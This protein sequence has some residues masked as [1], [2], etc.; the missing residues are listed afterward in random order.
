MSK[1]FCRCPILIGVNH[2]TAYELPVLASGFPVHLGM[3]CNQCYQKPIIGV[4]FKCSDCKNFV[5]CQNC[6]FIK[7]SIS[8][9]N[10]KGHTN[11]HNFEMFIIETS[12]ERKTYT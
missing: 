11:Q 8:F 6:Y 5:L 10:F 12:N 4:C 3:K 2:W 7:N 9:K 1:K